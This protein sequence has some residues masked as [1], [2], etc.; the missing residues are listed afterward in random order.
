MIRPIHILSVNEFNVFSLVVRCL[1]AKDVCILAVRPILPP[2]RRLLMYITD[3]LIARGRARLLIDQFPDLH[4]VLNIYAEVYLYN[5]FDHIEPWQNAFFRFEQPNSALADYAMACKHLVCNYLAPRHLD[6]LQLDRTIK[7]FPADQLRFSGMT[8]ALVGAFE[9]FGGPTVKN[10]IRPALSW[11]NP[12]INA[13]MATFICIYSLAW[14]ILRTRLFKPKP[15]AFFLAADFAPD[16]RN[17]DFYNEVSDGGRLLIVPRTGTVTEARQHLT[18]VEA[19]YDIRTP[20]DGLFGPLQ[21]LNAIGFIVSDM[22]GIFGFYRNAEP[23]IFFQFA[24]LP[25]RRAVLRAFFNRFAP[26]YFWGRDEYNVEHVIR[27]Q[28]INRSGG[29]SHGIIHSIPTYADH[30]PMWR[31]ANFDRYYIFGREM[32]KH[33]QDTWAEDMTVVPAGSFGFSR[34]DYTDINAQRPTDICVF[35]GVFS[36]NPRMT[37]LV[38]GLAEQ[39]PERTVWLQVKSNYLRLECGKNFVTECTAGLANVKHTTDP[40]TQIFRRAQYCFS[41]PSTVVIESMQFGLYSFAIDV[42]DIHEVCTFRDFPD[43][44]LQTADEAAARIHDIESSAY[45][46][47]REAYG[48]LTDLSGRVIYDTIREGFGL[49]P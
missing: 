26:Q 22:A 5:I 7:A 4:H 27:R 20:K 39:F 8:P 15:E 38:R 44:C 10:R 3:A 42:S 17:T 16:K 36:A 46:Y 21:F 25:L 14:V 2:F 45:T 49:N 34:A 19:D 13:V 41:D 1:L 23:G 6:I 33:H 11:P 29:Q 30:F 12:I 28:E 35:A 24:S 37:S 9:A 31:Y 40:M 43:L 47:K 32:Y 48:D 18:A